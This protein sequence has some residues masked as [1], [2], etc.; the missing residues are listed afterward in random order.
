M[1][2]SASRRTDIPAFYADWFINRLNAGYCLV[3]NPFNPNQIRRVSLTPEDVSGIVF[4]TKNATPLLSKINA[5]DMYEYYF[6]YS[7][8]PYHNDMERDIADKKTE[9]IPSFIE[10]TK[11]IGL[12]RMIWRYDPIIITE[13]YNIDY[14]T[15]AFARLCELLEGST[16]KCVFSFVIPYK[17][18]AKRLQNSGHK[19][20]NIQEKIQLSETLFLIAQKHGI[21]LCACCELAG[22]TQAGVQ[23]ISCIDATLF[24]TSASRDKNQRKRCNCA[25]SVD[26]GVYN[27]CMNGCVYCYA[28]HNE[29]LVKNN[30]ESHDSD[31]ELLSHSKNSSVATISSS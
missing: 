10:F 18:V 14:H 27:T 28:N 5:L 30:F 17:T 9:V 15:K 31:G 26:I 4:W 2:I 23:P 20:L 12:E 3:K 11:R 8:T 25:A 6:Q 29:S 19:E 7:I 24:N 1:I 21:T 16:R 13:R 22:L